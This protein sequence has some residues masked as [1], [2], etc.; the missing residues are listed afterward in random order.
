MF[1]VKSNDN[2]K[3]ISI[4]GRLEHIGLQQK[5]CINTRTS[6]LQ[7]RQSKCS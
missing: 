5:F 1:F 7:V 2:E 3:C 6:M 4:L